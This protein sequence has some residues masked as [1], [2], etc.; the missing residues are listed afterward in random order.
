MTHLTIRNLG[1]ALKSV[2]YDHYPTARAASEALDI[3]EN[4]MRR[5]WHNSRTGNHASFSRMI[6]VLSRLGYEVHFEV[7]KHGDAARARQLAQNT[8]YGDAR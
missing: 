8:Q 4:E 1:L 2:V 5:A 6:D 7:R 3:D